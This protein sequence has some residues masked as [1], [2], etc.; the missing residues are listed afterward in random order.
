MCAPR[1]SAEPRFFLMGER[2]GEGFQRVG[3]MSATQAMSALSTIAAWRGTVVNHQNPILETELPLDG[4]RFEGIVSPIVRSPVFAIR[5]RPK[6]IFT[7]EEYEDSE[8]LTAQSDREIVCAVATT[9]T[10]RSVDIGT[11]ISSAP[12]CVKKRTSSLSAR[13]EAATDIRECLPGRACELTPHDRVVSIEDTTEL[14]CAVNNYLDLRAVGEV[15]MLDCLRACMRLKPTRIV[16]GEV[17]GAEA[18]TLLKAWNTGHP[19]GMATVHANDAVAASF[20]WRAWSPR[21]PPLR[22]N[23]SS[24]KPWIWSS[25][26]MKSQTSPPAAKSESSCSSPDTPTGLIR[27]SMFES[28]QKGDG[29]MTR[30]H[31]ERIDGWSYRLAWAFVIG[32]AF[33]LRL[34]AAAGGTL[35]WETPCARSPRR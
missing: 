26:S 23:N 35:P 14:Q 33:S 12:L 19:G 8:I 3:Q 6:R 2:M 32:A 5:L 13:P 22:N 7:L 15:T 18:H 4:S 16:V 1:I 27:S 9:S 21:P 17:R 30:I 28:N 25:S 31:R 29:F 11:E 24:R 34:H 20:G 10:A